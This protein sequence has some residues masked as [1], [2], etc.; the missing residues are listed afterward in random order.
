MTQAMPSACSASQPA[1]TASSSAAGAVQHRDAAA[2]DRRRHVGVGERRPDHRLGLGH[3]LLRRAVVDGQRGHRDRRRRPIRSQALRPGP[4]KPCRACARSPT[5]VRL[6]DGQ[7][8]S[9]ICHSASVSSCAS[10]TTTWANGPASRSGSAVGQRGARRPRRS[11]GRPAQHRHQQQ[12]GV[13]G[14]DQLIDDS[15]MRTRVQAG[16]VRNGPGGRRRAL[17]QPDLVRVEPGSTPP[18]VGGD[19]PQVGH[20][21]GR[22][23][24]RPG[25]GGEGGGQVERTA[26]SAG[27]H[28]ISS[29]FLQVGT[30]GRRVCGLPR[31]LPQAPPPEVR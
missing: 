3:D 10:S 14:G 31:V 25:L 27:V 30:G 7:R 12:L 5:T 29:P 16:Q 2:A 15:A 23:D 24:H 4:V 26:G 20:Q 8:S 28:V 22:L 9:T 19:R 18:Q 17:Q 1:R 6:R 13:V 11:A 21:V